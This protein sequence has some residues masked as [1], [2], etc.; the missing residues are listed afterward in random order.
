MTEPKIKRVYK[1]MG[2]MSGIASVAMSRLKVSRF[3][4]LNDPF[5]L[6]GVNLGDPKLRKVFQKTRNEIDKDKGMLCFTTDWKNPLMWGHYAENHR[7]MALG[8]DVPSDRLTTVTYAKNMFEFTLQA[9]GRP[10]KGTVDKL[11]STKFY[12]WKYEKEVRMWVGL[13][14]SMAEGNM[15]FADFSAILNLKEIVLGSRSVQRIENVRR[16]CHKLY[17]DQVQVSQ[18]RIAFTRFEVLENMAATKADE[19]LGE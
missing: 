11:I 12:D 14:D 4:E 16:L 8:F 1:L 2:D 13:D 17:D 15:Q 3:K 5:E 10:A 18:A 6:L 7:G 9:D 19:K